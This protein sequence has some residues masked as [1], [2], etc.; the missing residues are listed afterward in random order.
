M[1]TNT[2]F[3]HWV[4]VALLI[5]APLVRADEPAKSFR[6]GAATSNITPK[7]GAEIIGGFAPIPSKHIHDELH[8]RCLV[9]DNGDTKLVIVVADNV[10]IAREVFDAAKAKLAE[11]TG[12]PADHMLMSATHTHSAVSARGD[13]RTRKSETLSDYQQLVVDRIVDGV[14]RAIHQLEPARI[15][16]GQAD[17][18]EELFNRRWFLTEGAEELRNPFGGTDQVRMNP[19]A[20]SP[21]LVRQAGPVDPE[22]SF[23][24]IQSSTGR[25]IALLA[26]YSLHYVGGVGSA[27]I[28]AD[29]FAVFAD[30]IQELLGAD[31]QD[32]PFVGI[33]CN[34]T[35]G[36]VNNINFREKAPPR[37]PYEKIRLV[38]DRVARAVYT[39]HQQVK[40]HDQAKLAAAQEEL[41]LA[42]R[43]PTAE[44]QS[45]ARETLAREGKPAW[46]PLEKIYAQ[47]L[48]QQ[49]DAPDQ[50]S[51][52][53]QALRIG[54]V[55]VFAIPFEVFTETGLEL[56]E[57]SPLRPAFTISLAN[58]SYGY[59]PTPRQHALGG[60]ET[61]L[62]TNFV[63]VEAST[64]ITSTLLRLMS[65]LAKDN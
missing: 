21:L 35:S 16:F 14:Q 27:D 12:I 24:S 36:D 57:R 32:P 5:A 41:V 43:K 13:S 46:H 20:A 45:Q 6:A 63:E 39:A 55:G 34:G 1:L 26:N 40:F 11:T 54:D 44:Q 4:F 30:R 53:L 65:G 50:V 58:G 64:K 31:R 61:W 33:L 49:A 29:Y 8:A 10:G 28:S 48:L 56:K 62:G 38:A 42:V 19:P 18:P 37:K 7:L 3:L 2:R 51:I 23:F 25:P 52:P 15:G 17:V 60:Y 9:L 59:L 22:V 47:R